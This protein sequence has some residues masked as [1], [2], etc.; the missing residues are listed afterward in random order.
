MEVVERKQRTREQTR[1]GILQTAKDIARREGWQAVSIRKIADA[2][3]YSAPVV[4]DYFDSRDRLLD[5]IRN[6]GFRHLRQECERLV[7]LYRDPEKLLYEISLVQWQFAQQQPELYQVMY[8]LNGANC[9][10][11][12]EESE[13]M[14]LVNEIVCRIIFSFIPKSAESIRRL[15][16]E[17]WATVHGLISLSLLLRQQQPIETSEQIYRETLRRFIRNLR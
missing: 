16:F 7:K 8:N 6:E 10:V 13:E 2:I 5:E 12:L 1:T 15:Y 3:E 11:S 4:Y 14:K 17:W 9:Q